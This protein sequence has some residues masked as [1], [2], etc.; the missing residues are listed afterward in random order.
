MINKLYSSESIPNEL[1]RNIIVDIMK[2]SL[3]VA[4]YERGGPPSHIQLSKK[5]I[6]ILHNTPNGSFALESTK[7]LN[8]ECIGIIC[9]LKVILNS[10]IGDGFVVTREE[11]GYQIR[12]SFI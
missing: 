9:G 5:Y 12:K 7:N 4:K 10:E 2:A 1:Y 8:K 11:D 3:E 6:D